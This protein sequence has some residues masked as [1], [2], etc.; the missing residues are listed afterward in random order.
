MS[1]EITTKTLYDS[2]RTF[3]GWAIGLA[4]ATA[5]YTSVYG[6]IDVTVYEELLDAFPPA[7]TEIFGL[8]DFTSPEGYLG[9]TVY[10]LIAPI[11][12][13]IFAI[14]IGARYVAG[15]EEA[16]TLELTAALPVSR[17]SLLMQRAL[18]VTVGALGGALVVY[19][20]VWALSIPLR[21]DVPTGALA[22]ANLQ[23]GLLAV[24][25]GTLALAVG[26]TTGRR[27]V[28]IGVS[29]TVAVF[30]YF[31]NTV[32]KSVEGLEWI[33]P[34][35]LWHY[36]DG[37]NVLLEGLDPGFSLVLVLVTL[38]LIGISLFVFDRRDIGT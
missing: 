15:D 31:G 8:E 5:I 16:G 13:A 17:S 35:S 11:L 2:R 20:T 33:E 34:L 1:F 4:G 14:A 36:Y 24:A 7:F 23:L 18:A 32:V 6:I 10:G 28:A 21:L 19:L 25:L 37:P 38:V 30:S 12:L 3:L 9:S 29:A 22:A 26:A 27:G